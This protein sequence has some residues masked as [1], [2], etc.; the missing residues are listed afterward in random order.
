VRSVQYMDNMF[1]NAITFNQPI[2]GNTWNTPALLSSWGMFSCANA[3]LSAHRLMS[4]GYSADG[5]PVNWYA[6][7]VGELSSYLCSA[8]AMP[9][10]SRAELKQA[11]DNC[12]ADN[13]QGWCNCGYSADCGPA[14]TSD[15]GNWDVSEVTSMSQ[16]FKDATAF[17]ADL[18]S[19]NTA[20]VTDMTQMFQSA[21]AFNGYSVG[22]WNTGQ[23]TSMYSMFYEAQTFNQDIGNWDTSKVKDMRQMFRSATS[24]D[25]P[26]STWNTRQVTDMYRMFA[27]AKMFNHD[28]STWDT[29]AVTSVQYMFYDAPAFNR[30]IGSW[31]MSNV[32]DMEGMFARSAVFDKPINT[33]DT[34]SVTN[35]NWMFQYASAFNQ[36]LYSWQTSSVKFMDGMFSYATAFNQQISIWSTPA[37]QSAHQMFICANAW[38]STYRLIDAG[39]SGSD[40]PPSAWYYA[41]NV[42][43]W[44]RSSP[45]CFDQPS[46]KKLSAAIIAVIVVVVVVVV[47]AVLLFVYRWSRRHVV[48]VVGV[49]LEEPEIKTRMGA[50]LAAH[51][52]FLEEQQ[53]LYLA[54]KRQAP[55][56]SHLAIAIVAEYAKQREDTRQAAKMLRISEREE[57][58]QQDVELAN[59]VDADEDADDASN[60]AS[61]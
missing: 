3:W 20:Q 25:R 45:L 55:N 61:P 1:D 33:W 60:G 18:W 31:N 21:K 2:S 27:H 14:S 50:R 35:M 43:T 19:W 16:L 37:L 59:P 52:A 23:V 15:I 30:P 40:G 54:T 47:G 6:S 28:I 34:S 48:C 17:D 49:P 10:K 26:L 4:G 57:R 29:S 13:A 8:P 32:K 42:E 5:P 22:N 38:L 44:E 51:R 46:S 7:T 58:R 12:L 56:V 53:K 9:F 36:P 41:G 39:A 24:F 11:V